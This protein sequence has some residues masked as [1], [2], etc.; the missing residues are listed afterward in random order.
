MR[1][2]LGGL[3]NGVKYDVQVRT[4][5]IAGDGPWSSTRTGTPRT[6]PGA[7]GIDSVTPGDESL[8]VS[9]SV[10]PDDGGA[11]ITSYDLRYIRSDAADKADANWSEEQ[12]SGSPTSL[13]H[14]ITG[15][16]NGVEYDL[17]VRAVN[18][19]GDGAWST[20]VGGT[21]AASAVT[22]SD[23][24]PVFAEGT[25]TT[26]SVDEDATAGTAVG[27]PVAATDADNDTLAYTLGGDDAGSFAIDD[28]HGSDHGGRRDYA[29]LRGTGHL[30]RQCHGHRPFRQQRRHRC[31]NHGDR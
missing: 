4:V 26:R 19:A 18:I 2:D 16:S 14:T 13:Q 5:N 27:G 8:A 11:A 3:S 25:S 7:P 9:W 31:D 12:G 28:R 29:G 20:S 17:Q 10:P 1:Y 21:P 24:A 23:A 6:V 30:R 22:P 15:L